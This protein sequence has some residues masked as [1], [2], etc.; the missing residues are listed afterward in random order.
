MRTAVGKKAVG[1]AEGFARVFYAIGVGVV[2]CVA[3]AF[4][5]LVVVK[6]FGISEDDVS[7]LA[8]GDDEFGVG[9]GEGFAINR[10]ADVSVRRQLSGLTR[11]VTRS[12]GCSFPMLSMLTMRSELPVGGVLHVRQFVRDQAPG[13]VACGVG[14]VGAR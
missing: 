13:V 3:I 9:S 10:Q 5:L 6:G 12:P 4:V 11:E 8:A 7:A 2:D 1:Q 14:R